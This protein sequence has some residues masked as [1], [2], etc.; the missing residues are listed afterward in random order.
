MRAEGRS[1]GFSKRH[2]D[3][4]DGY[5]EPGRGI[6]NRVV[7]THHQLACAPFCHATNS[8][9]T[10]KKVVTTGRIFASGCRLASLLLF[11]PPLSPL[12]DET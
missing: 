12:P 7:Q 6:N 11:D 9:G 4:R 3:G 8:N 5:P 1:T 10:R 2:V